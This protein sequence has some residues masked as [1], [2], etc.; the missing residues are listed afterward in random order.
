MQSLDLKNFPA[1]MLP[2][3]V[4]IKQEF[5]RQKVEDIPGEI[6]VKMEPYVENLTGKRIAVGV[7]SRGIANIALII[8]TVIDVLLKAGAKPFIIPVM[9]SH[10]GAVAEGQAD[11]LA[12]FGISEATMGVPLNA[13]MDVE[14]I[15]EI[16]PGY[17]IYVAKSAL[18]ADGIVIIPR[19]KPHTCFR[20]PIESGICKM[21]VIGLGKRLGADSVHSHGFASFTEY[22]P[23]IGQ[24][25]AGKVNLLFAVAL[26]EN[27]FEDT[28]K[29]E[30]VPKSDILTLEREK[31]L[32]EEAR[33]SMG[34]ILFDKFDVLIIDEI[35]KN[36]SGDGQDPNVTGLYITKCVSGGPEFKKSAILDVTEESHGNANG[37][38]MVDVTTRKLFDKI[39][40]ISM[41]TNAFT[42]TEIEAAKVPMV[43]ATAED[44]I[45]M[46]V[47]MCNGV[48][49][50]CHKIVWIK[51]TLEL[52]DVLISEPLLA[53]A[54]AHPDIE[55]VS[56]AKELIFIN[57]EPQKNLI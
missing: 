5:N 31:T 25:I 20:G 2:R 1:I 52:T 51:N 16:E 10:G 13:S 42:S 32:L 4:R 46:A 45:R 3:F 44:A 29:I 21:L 7:G 37:V 14:C 47:K 43:A 30:V 41:Y 50:Y 34:R 28:Y 24:M 9:G 55:V 48:D 8:K 35:G 26:V 6:R 27:A 54:E 33:R 40:Y 19:V 49:P 12:S 17:P 11:L 39:D 18:E 22:I 53:E 15:G 57:G 56:E 38:G 36:I 23:R